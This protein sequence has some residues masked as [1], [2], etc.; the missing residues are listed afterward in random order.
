MIFSD[1]FVIRH[2]KPLHVLRV[3]IACSIALSSIQIFNIPHASWS[4]ITIIVVMGPV[5]YYGSVIA[6]ANHRL[7]GTI[8]GA[9]LGLS[10]FFLPIKS[11]LI[12]D[13]VFLLLLTATMSMVI[14]RYSYV[15]VVAGLTL[16]IVAIGTG[17]IA[18]AQ[19]RAVNVI[20]GSVLSIL[21]SQLFFPSR[22]FVHYQLLVVDFFQ[23]IGD[24]YLMHNKR[25]QGH[26]ETIDY[27]F[28]VLHNNLIQQRSLLPHIAKEKKCKGVNAIEV[29]K[30]EQ[31]ILSSVET[32]VS[33]D[34][35]KKSVWLKIQ[36]NSELTD[37]ATELFEQ[38]NNLSI[39]VDK[40]LSHRIPQKDIRLLKIT[41]G[42][43]QSN[44]AEGQDQVSNINFFGYLWLNNELAKN[45]SMVSYYLAKIFYKRA[46]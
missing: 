17:D 36:K 38:I 39:E 7:I 28:K 43:A 33:R 34:W 27:N 6:K 3:V 2:Q 44:A 15:A 13:L 22:A 19:W 46:A 12:Y 45:I 4:L 10:L 1:R 24:Y 26:D 9:V 32:L 14:G 31:W 5:S 8:I 20:A 35:R 25:L 18:A 30:L 42:A 21:C 11:I 37:G 41:K 29:V 23:I 40:G 16:V